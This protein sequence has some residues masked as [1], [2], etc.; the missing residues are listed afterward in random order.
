MADV[1]FELKNFHKLQATIERN[2]GALVRGPVPRALRSVG[3]VWMTEAKRRCPVDTGTLRSSG[4]VQGPTVQG[5]EI[6]VRLVFGGPAAS[7]AAIVHENLTA[8]HDVGQAKYL[9]SVIAERG[10][11]LTKEV[12][13]FV[14][15]G[16]RVHG[17]MFGGR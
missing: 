15:G 3:E 14:A 9:E 4:H 5:H 11:Q 8:H 1:V 16:A 13:A 7:Y 6:I 2:F 12:V 10:R 17:A